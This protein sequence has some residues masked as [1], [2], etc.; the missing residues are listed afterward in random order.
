MATPAWIGATTGQP[1]LASQVNQFLG[2]HQIECLYTG[3]SLGGQ[4]TAGSG[5]VNTNGL[6]A[7]QLFTPSAAQTPGRFVLTLSVTGSPAPLALSIQTSTG[8]APSGTSV[9][10]TML[11]AAFVGASAGSVSIPMPCSL[12]AAT[13][14]WIV[15]NAVGDSSDFYSLSKSNQTSGAS[16]SPTGAAWT[17]QTYGLLYMRFDQSVVGPLTH[18]W[19]DFGA[20]WTTFG[21]NANTSVSSL[22]EYTVAQSAT[23]VSSARSMTYSGQSLAGVA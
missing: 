13:S 12:A 2:T 17:A 6:Y 14:Y 22:D 10:S 20:R 15:A 5:A 3:V 19:E 1:P 11:P 21:R 8:S 4:A 7:A 18:T 16:T 9:V 23:A